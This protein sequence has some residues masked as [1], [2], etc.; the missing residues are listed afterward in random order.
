LKQQRKSEK[1]GGKLE[2]KTNYLQKIWR[3]DKKCLSLP[4]VFG[5]VLDGTSIK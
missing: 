2:Q 4:E 5:I 1:N 3:F